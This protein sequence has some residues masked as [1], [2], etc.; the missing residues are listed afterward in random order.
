MKILNCPVNGPRAVTEFAYWGELRQ[1]PDPA[2]VSDEQWADYVFNRN[3]AP[4]IK[5]EW[6]CHTPS[7]TWFIVERDTARDQVLRTYLYG[8]AP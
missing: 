6:W 4:G 2:A 5:M 3:G 8:E 1:M 7:N